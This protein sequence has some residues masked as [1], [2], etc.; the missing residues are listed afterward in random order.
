MSSF[1]KI[2]IV[3]NLGVDP[4]VRFLA[5]GKPVC[6]FSVAVNEKRGDKEEVQWFKVAVFGNQAEPCGQYLAKGRQVLVEG[7]ISLE[8]WK[9][10]EGDEMADLKITAHQVVF[11]GSKDGGGETRQSRSAANPVGNG[12]QADD[13]AS[14]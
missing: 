8:K 6:N 10:K 13:L 9:G 7:R 4:S 11:L 5:D 3:G 2:T 12:N 14:V 1:N